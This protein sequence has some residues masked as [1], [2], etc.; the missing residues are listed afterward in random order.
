MELTADRVHT[1]R[2]IVQTAS[3]AQVLH[4]IGISLS[5]ASHVVQ[6]NTQILI[7]NLANLVMLVTCAIPAQLQLDLLSHLKTE[8]FANQVS[9]V[10]KDL[11]QASLVLLELTVHRKVTVNL[12]NVYPVQS[13]LSETRLVKHLAKSVKA[14]Q[15]QRLDLQHANVL[16]SIENT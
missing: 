10:S 8:P 12:T 5:V 9:T 6:A 14:L 11:T 13:T 2:L 16:V 15:Y 4:L 1:P 3:S 7:L